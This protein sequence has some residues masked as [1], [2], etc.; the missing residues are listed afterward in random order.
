MIIL[1]S[2]MS[3]NDFINFVVDAKN[4]GPLTLY[5]PFSCVTVTREIFA[6]KSSELKITSMTTPI[7]RFGVY[8]IIKKM[9]SMTSVS[10]RCNYIINL[11]DPH[12]KVVIATYIMQPTRTGTVISKTNS[13]KTLIKNLRNTP[14]VNVDSRTRPH[15]LK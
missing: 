1:L 2:V 9:T 7:A 5:T 3:S 6:T 12:F 14:A 4:N 8:K 10:D 15:D 13:P 11:H